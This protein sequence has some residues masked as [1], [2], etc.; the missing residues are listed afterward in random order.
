MC[1][2]VRGWP[3]GSIRLRRTFGAG[4]VLFATFFFVL[5]N[6]LVDLS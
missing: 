5:A 1:H 6:L 3:D 2:R 4:G